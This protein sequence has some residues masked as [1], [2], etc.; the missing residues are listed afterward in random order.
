MSASTS[1]TAAQAA[2]ERDRAA[3][4]R[5][6]TTARGYWARDLFSA[7]R[8]QIAA[9]ISV[10]GGTGSSPR[11]SV[12]MGSVSTDYEARIAQHPTHQIFAWLERHLQ[13]MRYSGPY[14]LVA[15]VTAQREALV[16]SLSEQA[17]EELLELD[18]ALQPPAYYTDYDIH[19]HPGGLVG[20]PLAAFVYRDAVQGGGVV[21]KPALHERFARAAVAGEQPRRILDMG[22]GFGRGTFAF[23]EAA[24]EAR[25]DGIDLS[26][27]CVSLAAHDAPAPLRSRLHFTQANALDNSLPDGAFDLITSTML[28]HEMPEDAVRE[29]IRETGRLTAPGG[30]VAHLDF[31]PPTDPLLRALYAGHARR[32]N[33][34]YLLDHSRIDLETAYREAGFERVEVRDFAEDD[35][36]LA[37]PPRSWRLPWKMIVAYKPGQ[38]KESKR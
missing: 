36:A 15:G 34:P 24:P 27:S 21:G 5:F 23:A 4:Q 6:V 10:P 35:D 18:P 33:E 32:N 30:K 1:A 3:Y 25:V 12:S 11:D 28:L 17:D 31:L 20:D 7:L 38:A 26:A 22:C 16:R 29:L 2:R 19:Q 8:R 13:R 14:G 37:D 9:D